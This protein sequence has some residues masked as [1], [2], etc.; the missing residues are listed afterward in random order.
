LKSRV[1]NAEG[2]QNGVDAMW[3]FDTTKLEVSSVPCHALL[4]KFTV[5]FCDLATVQREDLELLK[6][7]VR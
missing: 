5:A 4:T 6:V 3:R 7:I 1:Q 2:T